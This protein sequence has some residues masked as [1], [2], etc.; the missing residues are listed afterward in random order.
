MARAKIVID[1]D[2]GVDDA[3]ALMLAFS[4]S[5]LCEVLAV[6]CCHGNT[7]VDNV[8]DNVL[9][10]CEACDIKQLDIF[11]GCHR[12]LIDRPCP[13]DFFGVDGFGNKSSEFPKSSIGIKE[14]HAVHALIRLA[15][16]YPKEISVVAIAPLTNLALAQRIDPTFFAN[17]KEICI[18][19][20]NVDAIGNVTTAAEFN[21]FADPEAAYI[22]L[23]EEANFTIIPWETCEKSK[24]NDV[25]KFFLLIF[26]KNSIIII[27]FYSKI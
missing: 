11:R 19:G 18:L 23:S 8:C 26:I 3:L 25:T 24:M 6:T 17:L 12:P 9:R 20:G 27:Y 5:D 10:V 13:E 16:E 14:E 1:T 4:R 7:I 15:K 22:V 2:C 21:F